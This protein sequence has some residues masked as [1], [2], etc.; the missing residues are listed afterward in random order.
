MYNQGL[1]FASHQ[2]NSKFGVKLNPFER[3]Q[4]MEVN[5][6]SCFYFLKKL[7]FAVKINLARGKC[8]FYS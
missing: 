6:E 7:Y 2:Y 4:L 3:A 1:L 5:L 8:I